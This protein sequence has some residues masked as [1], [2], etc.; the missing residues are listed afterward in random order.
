[1]ILRDEFWVTGIMVMTI[2][3]VGLLKSRSNFMG[4]TEVLILT[5]KVLHIV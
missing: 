1:M 5:V 2:A 3:E 4:C